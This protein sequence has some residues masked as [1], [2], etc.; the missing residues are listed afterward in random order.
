MSS[1]AVMC[2]TCGL[3]NTLGWKSEDGAWILMEVLFALGLGMVINT[4]LPA[5]QGAVPES[6]QAVGTSTF[7]FV[8]SLANILTATM[9][10]TISN[11]RFEAFA[12]EISDSA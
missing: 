7:T 11:N 9:P 10:A 5:C 1:F 12:D 2:I 3:F 4:L 8:Q 6:D